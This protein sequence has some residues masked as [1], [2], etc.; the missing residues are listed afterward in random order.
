VKAVDGIGKPEL[1]IEQILDLFGVRQVGFLG[2]NLVGTLW[3]FRLDDVAQYELNIRS[4]AIGQE[5]FGELSSLS[6]VDDVIITDWNLQRSQ[7]SLRHQ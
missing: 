3:S 1:G 6:V 4:L 7:A 2:H 5:R